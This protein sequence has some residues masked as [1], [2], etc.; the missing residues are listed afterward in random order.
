MVLGVG[1]IS[2]LPAAGKKATDR[3]KVSAAATKPDQS[4]KQVVTVTMVIDKG[5]HVYAN[6]VGNPK[7]PLNATVVSLNAKV[8]PSK[9][10]V[11]YPPGKLLEDKDE[12]KFQ[13]YEGKVTI[14]AVVQRANGD[15]G[16]LDVS[17]R[18]YACNA[19]NCFPEANVKLTV[20]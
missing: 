16:P 5:W 19:N 4:G 8:K 7:Y 12:G 20:D 3:V 13:I 15:V 14:R 6:P 9:V 17:V 10:N 1:V 2:D 18:F 11:A